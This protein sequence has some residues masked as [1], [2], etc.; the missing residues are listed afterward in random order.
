M[1]VLAPAI[2][3]LL[4]W[5]LSAAFALDE[6]KPYG[7]VGVTVWDPKEKT[8]APLNDAA[9]PAPGRT[10]RAHLDANTSCE[11]VI[12]AFTIGTGA[13]AN[14]WRPYRFDLEAW[15]EKMGPPAGEA[16]AWSGPTEPF[17]VFAVLLPKGKAGAENVRDLVA[18]LRDPKN[19]PAASALQARLLREELRKWSASEAPNTGLPESTPARIGGTLRAGADFPWR[20]HARKLNFSETRPGVTVFRHAGK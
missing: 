16:W 4:H 17:E 6:T 7:R 19:A 3:V 8:E 1:F 5:S 13:L 20:D 11:A 9:H 10:L 18:R 15:V 14:A 2:I 12:A